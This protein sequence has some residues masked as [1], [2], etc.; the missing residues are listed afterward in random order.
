MSATKPRARL[1]RGRNSLRPE[2]RTA[3]SALQATPK[4]RPREA[5]Q[6]AGNDASS[7]RIHKLVVPGNFNDHAAEEAC[8]HHRT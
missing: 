1:G 5:A 8:L 3:S 2:I 7:A 4:I 6:H